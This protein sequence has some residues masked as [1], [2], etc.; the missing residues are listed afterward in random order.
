MKIINQLGSALPPPQV[1]IPA[2][3]ESQLIQTKSLKKRSLK[4]LQT[5]FY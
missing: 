5:I 1:V 2:V 3:M 4:D